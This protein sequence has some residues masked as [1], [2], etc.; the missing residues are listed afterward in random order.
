MVGKG[1]E[2]LLRSPAAFE[3]A[4]EENKAQGEMRWHIQGYLRVSRN[5]RNKA[6]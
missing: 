4:N 3:A 6:H 1:E 5:I 2:N